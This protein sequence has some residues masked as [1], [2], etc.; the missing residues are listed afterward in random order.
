MEKDGQSDMS[1]KVSGL[2]NG[3]LANAHRQHARSPLTQPLVC[4]GGAGEL[5]SISTSGFPASLSSSGAYI[6]TLTHPLLEVMSASPPRR[7]IGPLSSSGART[8]P[9]SSVFHPW[10]AVHPGSL[11]GGNSRRLCISTPVPGF[12]LMSVWLASCPLGV[13]GISMK[14]TVRWRM[15]PRAP[16]FAHGR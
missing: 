2:E 8:V 3:L 15:S 14:M 16:A 11:P 5:C 1:G 12:G 9:S 6:T 4:Y 13:V 7:A 10:P